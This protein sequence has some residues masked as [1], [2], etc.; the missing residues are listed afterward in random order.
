MIKL[1]ELV[2]I[3]DL[4]RQ[5]LSVSA[6]TNVRNGLRPLRYA[7]CA[8]GF[9]VCCSEMGAVDLAGHGTVERGRLGPGHLVMID[10]DRGFVD[11]G[12]VKTELAA[13]LDVTGTTG[14]E[15]DAI[16]AALPAPI[17][18]LLRAL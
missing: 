2:M 9:V 6:I 8:D 16:K 1:G 11:D 10:P 17:R 15:L 4:H 13:Q 12:Q 3:L 7:V 5:G 18:K 14:G